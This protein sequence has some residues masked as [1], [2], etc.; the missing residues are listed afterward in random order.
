MGV[1]PWRLYFD[2]SSHKNGIGVGILII[3]LEN[4]LTKLKFRLD[5]LFSNNEAEY[6]ALIAG[7]EMFLELG[8]KD[9][10]IRGDSEL[11]IKKLT[12]EYKCVIENL[13]IYFATSTA[14]LKHFDWANI[15]H[16]PRIENQEA[17]DLPQIASGYRITEIKFEELMKIME[18]LASKESG[19]DK[20]ST[21]KLGGPRE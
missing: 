1:Q 20:L 15:Q 12:K 2:G 18:K 10:E 14:L 21:P 9:F 17:N 5:K 19:L 6:E 3:S 8:E 4:I 13:I 16:V 11:V 7:L